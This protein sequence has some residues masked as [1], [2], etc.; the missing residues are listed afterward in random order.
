MTAGEESLDDLE[1]RVSGQ[2]RRCGTHRLC[3]GEHLGVEERRLVGGGKARKLRR[4]RESIDSGVVNYR[5][6]LNILSELRYV[7]HMPLLLGGPWS[8]KPAQG[9]AERLVVCEDKEL[10]DFQHQAK[11]ADGRVD[12]QQLPVERAVA[13]L[14]FFEKKERGAQDER[15]KCCRMAPT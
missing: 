2:C 4:T 15:Q 13:G 8:R 14:S 5:N 7:C 3:S 9:V 6:V 1:V 11:V 10:P 12:S